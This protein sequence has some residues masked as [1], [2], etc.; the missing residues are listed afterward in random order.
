MAGAIVASTG[1]LQGTTL[2]MLSEP[3]RR[4]EDIIVLTIVALIL[5][6]PILQFLCNKEWPQ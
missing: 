2:H 4:D 3:G 6:L 1:W 5:L